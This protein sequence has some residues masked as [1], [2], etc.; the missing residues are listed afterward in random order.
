MWTTQFW[1]DA[2]ERALKTFVQVFVATYSATQVTDMF[3]GT[4][5]Q[6]TLTLAAATAVLSIATSVVSTG[7]GD[8]DS[9]S[10]VPKAKQ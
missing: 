10:L 7:V 3:V 4:S 8:S 2:G 5:I 9:A 1:K 6:E